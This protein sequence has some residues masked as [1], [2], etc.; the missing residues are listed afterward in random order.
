MAFIIAAKLNIKLQ[1]RSVLSTFLI[2][3]ILVDIIT[4]WFD[5]IFST[6]ANDIAFEMTFE[7]T[8]TIE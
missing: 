2:K 3:L 6:I 5:W 1:S 8:L 7:M 4:F